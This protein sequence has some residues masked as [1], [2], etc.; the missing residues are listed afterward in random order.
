MTE[1][2]APTASTHRLAAR[3]ARVDNGKAKH[4][5]DLWGRQPDARH[6]LHG[7]DHVP[8]DITYGIVDR[9]HRRGAGTQAP[10]RPENA[11]AYAHATVTPA[12]SRA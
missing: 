8:P 4:L 11:A 9:L 2:A 3:L 6:R 12:P 1:I 10:V 7:V 5:A